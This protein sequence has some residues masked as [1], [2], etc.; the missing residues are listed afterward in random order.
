MEETPRP[1]EPI[2]AIGVAAARAVRAALRYRRPMD[3]ELE[4]IAYMRGALVDTGA[5]GSRA[6]LTRFGD[7]GIIGVAEGL[8]K[9]ERRWAIAHELGHFEAHAGVSFL[10]LCSKE[11]LISAYA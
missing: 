8:S 2:R 3:I 4:V 7:R 6:S 9:V 11:D 5:K 10:G 1:R